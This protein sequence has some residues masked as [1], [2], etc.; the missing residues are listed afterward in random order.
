MLDLVSQSGKNTLY[1]QFSSKTNFDPC[2]KPGA[3]MLI[4]I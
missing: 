3:E 4:L 2:R 1:T